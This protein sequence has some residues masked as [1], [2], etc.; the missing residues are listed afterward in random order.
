MDTQARKASDYVE[1]ALFP[2][3][4]P[5]NW[6]RITA[7]L[8]AIVAIVVIAPNWR[9]VAIP[10]LLLLAWWLLLTAVPWDYLPAMTVHSRVVAARVVVAQRFVLEEPEGQVRA[11]F[12]RETGADEKGPRL[13]LYNAAGQARLALRALDQVTE[14]QLYGASGDF[15]GP[16]AELRSTK[17]GFALRILGENEDL[18]WSAPPSST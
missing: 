11:Y 7:A 8:V 1:S 2:G 5:K 16:R 13:V 15:E 12:G 9:S 3:I 6:V 4:P 10:G 14:L 17:D 18:L